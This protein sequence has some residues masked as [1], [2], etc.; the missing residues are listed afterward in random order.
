MLGLVSVQYYE[1][2]NRCMG[3]ATPDFFRLYMVPGMFHC[4]GGVGTGMFD[5][6]SAILEWVEKGSALF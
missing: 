5:A 6:L 4:G 1:N 3:S 2:V